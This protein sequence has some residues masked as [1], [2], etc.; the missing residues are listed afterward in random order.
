QVG[1]VGAGQVRHHAHHERDL[2]LLLRAVDLDVVLDLHPRRPVARDEFLAVCH[3]CGLR[4]RCRSRL[5]A[6]APAAGTGRPPWGGPGVRICPSPPPPWWH[7]ADGPRFATTPPHPIAVASVCRLL[8][9]RMAGLMRVR[10]AQRLEEAAT[11][12]TRHF[13]SGAAAADWRAFP[14]P[15]TAQIGPWRNG[16]N[17]SPGGAADCGGAM[18]GFAALLRMGEVAGAQPPAHCQG[19]RIAMQRH[20]AIADAGPCPARPAAIDLPGG[21]AR[22]APPTEAS[23]HPRLPGILRCIEDE[24]CDP[25]LGTDTLVRRFHVS[26]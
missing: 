14:A 4:R 2:D 15:A 17:R 9:P 18:K 24:L 22:T 10:P 23:A 12:R 13:V 25:A 26:R 7:P 11:G 16:G 1:G 19:E 21:S 5:P 6:G 3:G 20:Q 8:A